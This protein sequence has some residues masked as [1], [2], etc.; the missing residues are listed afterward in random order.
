LIKD[1]ALISVVGH[2]ELLYTAKQAAGTTK[3]YFLFFTMA[4]L[5]YLLITLL[6]SALVQRIQRRIGR[7]MPSL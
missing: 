5:L 4:A 7:W 6:S 2:S 1:S 3:H